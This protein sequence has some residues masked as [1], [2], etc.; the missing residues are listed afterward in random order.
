MAYTFLVNTSPANGAVAMYNLI[1]TLMTAGWTKVMDSDGITYSASGVQVTHGGAG[2]GGFANNNAWVRLQAPPVNGGSVVNQTREITIQK[3]TLSTHTNWRIKYSASA[4]FT[5]GSPAITV[6]PS[7]T[8]EVFMLGA[9]TDASPTFYTW[10]SGTP[11]DCRWHIAA[12]G[13]AEFY[14]FVAWSQIIGAFG[15]R[16][17]MCLDVMAD[18]S[19]PAADVDPAV[20]YASVTPMTE[21]LAFSTSNTTNPSRARAWLGPTSAAGASIT[22]NNVNVGISL[23]GSWFAGNTTIGTNPWTNTEDLFPCLWGNVGTTIPRGVKGIST[24]FKM[25]T[26]LHVN[27]TVS[28]ATG[29]RD[30]IYYG[31]LWL[32]WSGVGVLI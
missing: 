15:V 3:G 24:L 13:A 12:G 9:G 21:I 7:A 26:M 6:T 4:L 22:S 27:G 11:G 25:G 1:A 2:T 18:G 23:Y 19:Y 30:K 10:M 31:C 14:S 20:I 17:I 28:S 29:T 32:P 16:E 8:D 5:G